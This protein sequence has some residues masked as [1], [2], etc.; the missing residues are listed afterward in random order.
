MTYTLLTPRE[1]SEADRAVNFNLDKKGDRNGH[2]IADYTRTT[3]HTNIKGE[4]KT[5][6][7]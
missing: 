5:L 7:N 3:T 1:L 2:P 6:F 4:Q